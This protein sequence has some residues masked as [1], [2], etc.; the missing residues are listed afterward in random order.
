MLKTVDKSVLVAQDKRVIG[1]KVAVDGFL[2][3]LLVRIRIHRVV[4]LKAS[5]K[6][7]DTKN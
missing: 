2:N 4:Q 7:G 3:E 5:K 1:F 6:P